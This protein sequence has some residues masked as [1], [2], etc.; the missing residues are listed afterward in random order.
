MLKA[1]VPLVDAL[2]SVYSDKTNPLLKRTIE[3]KV[4]DDVS[5]GM[6]LSKS[7]GKHP[8]VFNSMFVNIIKAGKAQVYWIKYYSN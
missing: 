7:M 6:S 4:I 1:G 3:K 5:S 2:D 8:K